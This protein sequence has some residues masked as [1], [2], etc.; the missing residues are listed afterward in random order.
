MAAFMSL[1]STPFNGQGSSS[2]T[3]ANA[4]RT[5]RFVITEPVV[6]LPWT[7]TAC[8]RPCGAAWR[9]LAPLFSAPEVE[10]EGQVAAEV[11]AGDSA[12]PGSA[13]APAGWQREAR[14]RPVPPQTSADQDIRHR[15]PRR[16]W[17]SLPADRWARCGTPAYPTEHHEQA[18]S[19]TPCGK[20]SIPAG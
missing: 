14:Q 6:E 13:Q 11:P 18:R 17:L 5:N 8:E 15:K 1:R 19:Q 4:I 12:L 9:R 20:R 3:P 7:I 2:D 10:L 16:G